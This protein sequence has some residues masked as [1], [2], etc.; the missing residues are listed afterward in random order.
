MPFKIILSQII[1]LAFGLSSAFAQVDVIGDQ[2]FLIIQN[3]NEINLPFFSNQ[4]LDTPNDIVQKAVIVIHGANRNADDYYNSIYN[5]ASDLGVLSETIIIAPQF[6]IT[7]DLNHWQPS[8]EFAFWSG[9]T[10][11]SSG[12]LSNSTNEHPRG[13]EISSYT[14]MDSLTAHLLTIYPNI[15]DIVLLGNSAGGQFVNR[16]AAGSDQEAE[17]KIRYI[18]SAPSSYVYMDEY[19]YGE[20]LFPMTWELPENCGEYNDYKYGLDDLNHYMSMMGIDSIRERY[21]RRKIQYLI[22]SIDTGGTQD[23]ES[24]TQGSNRLERCIIYYNYLQYFYGSQIIDSQ[25]IALISGVGHDY[26][27]IFS[28][29]CG[30]SAVFNYGDCEQ[31][32]NLVLPTSNFSSN[33]N[34]GTY[35]YPV[36]FINESVAGTHPLSSFNWIINDSLISSS[37]NFSHTF[38]YPGLF[39][40]S[41]IAF[42]QVGFSDTSV[43]QSLVQ[44][45]TVYGD[46]DWDA[47]V[48]D[49]DASLVLSHITGDELLS[50]LQQATGD[51]SNSASLSAFDA[52]LILQFI[53]G[54]LEGI[55]IE[56]SDSFIANGNL[57]SPEILGEVGEIVTI[58]ISIENSNNLYSFSISFTYNNV[59]L[60]SGSVYLNT[61]SN[62]GFLVESSVSDSGSIIVTGAS[63]TSI[64]GDLD[65]F[66]MYF[67]PTEFENGQLEIECNQIMLNEV[68]QQ[69]SFSI[70][71]NN[72]LQIGNEVTPNRINLENNFP[73]PFNNNT[74]ISFYGEIN[75][76]V[77]L[78][79]N[80]IKGRLVKVLIDNKKLKGF[81]TIY[82]SGTNDLGIKVQSGIYFYTLETEGFKGTKK[83]LL[84]K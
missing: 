74:L 79:I 24:M 55:P 67:I 70:L 19:R 9:T 26:N 76:S 29:S 80:D 75:S 48:T 14:I 71:I 36:N 23:C 59:Q 46:I 65:L 56:N 6:L 57:H 33:N 32:N 49:N 2:N 51:V 15:Q 64:G 35:P 34:V 20:F 17:G 78:Y 83:M 11:W 73:N 63:P 42:D 41:L 21:S 66:T 45:D 50:P 54:N 1:F 22:G 8:I 81:Q 37:E 4:S 28:S 47:E 68:M 53:S 30:R 77:Y 13:Y 38:S 5:N 58:P 43:F 39:D 27:G 12:G 60:E 3:N 7:A 84:L 44:I 52:S 72:Q 25:Q 69:Q 62:H 61:I 82:W 31:Y 18:V 16:Y 40:V 10:P